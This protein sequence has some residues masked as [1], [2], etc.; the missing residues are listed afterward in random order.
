MSSD[1]RKKRTRG[2]GCRRACRRFHSFLNH[3]KSEGIRFVRVVFH[4]DD[5]SRRAETKRNARTDGLRDA[6]GAR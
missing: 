1:G 3:E 5:A 2:R 6:P 4:G